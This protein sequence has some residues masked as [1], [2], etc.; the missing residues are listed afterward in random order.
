M[1]NAAGWYY[2]GG[3]RG[4]WGSSLRRLRFR[5][6]NVSSGLDAGVLGGWLICLSLRFGSAFGLVRFGSV[7]SGLRWFECRHSIYMVE[8]FG[9]GGW[10]W[11]VTILCVCSCWRFNTRMYTPFKGCSLVI[12]GH[13]PRDRR[14]G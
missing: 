9:G 14:L 7:R 1:V 10:R 12:V 2:F 13:L 4:W 11:F 3:F 8:L 5:K 6:F